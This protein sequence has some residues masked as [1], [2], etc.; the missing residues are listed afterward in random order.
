M[1]KHSYSDE[2]GDGVCDMPCGV[3][4]ID[5]HDEVISLTVDELAAA[6]QAHVAQRSHG[7]SLHECADFCAAE[8]IALMS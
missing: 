3:Q 2:D 6:I 1:L 8:I 7:Y 5:I 4:L